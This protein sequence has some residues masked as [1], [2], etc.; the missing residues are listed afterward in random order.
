MPLLRPYLGGSAGSGKSTTLRT[1]LQHLR[2]LFQKEAINATVELTAYTGVAAFNIGFGAKTACSCFRIFPNT[3]FKKELKGEQFRALEKQW[4]NAVLL[5]VD[6]I[7]FIGRGF[8]H[9]M[10]CRLQQAKRGSFAERGLDPNK[11]YFGDISMILVG[12][13]GQL[14]PI[15]DVSFC[16]DETTY[17]TCPKPLWNI[18]GHAQEGRKLLRLFDE[19]IMLTRI[20]R[21]KDDLWWTQSALRLRDFEMTK[22]DYEK[23]L[24]HDLDRGHL[25]SEQKEY[26]RT[27]AVWLC[28]RCEDVGAENGKRLAHKAQD[29]KLLVHRIHACHSAHKAAKRQPSSAFDGLRSIINLVRGCKVMITRN[30][31]Y[32]YG[33]ANGTRGSLVG[34]VYSAGAP[35]GTFPEV[36]VVEVPE[37]C[38]PAFYPSEPKWVPILPKVSVKEGTRQTREQFPLVAGYAMTVNKAQGL[39]LKEGVVINLTSGKRFKAASKHGLPFVAF[40]RSESF[41]MTAFKNLP[42]WDDFQKGKDSDMLRMRK[43]FTDMLD[44]KHTETMRKYSQFKTAEDE[45]EAYELWRERR[46]REPKRL[47]VQ[48]QQFRMHCPACAAQWW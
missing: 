33:L 43:R 47:K 16:D 40:T 22:E 26:F 5:I 36:L 23:W 2:L 41:E 48:P 20:H 4:E 39:T 32:K 45:N 17:S 35:V 29:E 11:Y 10:D 31:A 14:E 15:G 18:W 28:T 44:R 24:Q 21:S 9:R 38:G 30:I 42:P 8:F 37:Y 19:A 7:S 27:Q 34:V 13:F 6:E 25:S 12:D 1:V 3:A 46:E